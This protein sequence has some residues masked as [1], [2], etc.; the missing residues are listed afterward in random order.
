[1]HH[2]DC[3]QEIQGYREWRLDVFCPPVC[4]LRYCFIT[5]ISRLIYFSSNETHQEMLTFLIVYHHYDMLRKGLQVV[6]R[7]A[8]V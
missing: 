7:E 6:L 1:M 5:N 4:Y 2:C 8:V 3:T